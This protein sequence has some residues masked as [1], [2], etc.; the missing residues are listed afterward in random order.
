MLAP[1]LALF[2]VA[3]GPGAGAA[4]GASEVQRFLEHCGRAL[5]SEGVRFSCAGLAA[6]VADYPGLSPPEA[7]R[8]HLGSLKAVG[9]GETSSVAG[10][11]KVGDRVRDG[12]RFAARRVNG[13]VLLEGQAVAREIR[14][15]ITRLVSCGAPAGKPGD[16]CQEILPHLAL[17]GADPYRPALVEPSFRGRKVPI[18]Q[19]CRILNASET[20][21]RLACGEVAFL[22]LN[23]LESAD[24][25]VRFVEMMRDQLL[26]NLPGA[27]EGKERPCR[28]GG[29]AARC[30]VVTTG[31][32][33][34]AA[35]FYVGAAVVDEAPVSVQCGQ[36]AV[37]QGVHPVCASILTF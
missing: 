2:V 20:A 8:L 17:S 25:M 37:I 7:L 34:G 22:A 23:R 13:E 16:R 21:F 18:P 29:V 9:G 3:T 24:S 1:A 15:G 5:I 33:P 35:L 28:I 10:S 31:S 19:G 4:E 32:G 30:K 11:L 14:A 12:F 6:S 26:S 36:Q 27:T